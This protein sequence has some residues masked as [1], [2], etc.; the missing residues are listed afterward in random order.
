MCIYEGNIP[1]NHSAQPRTLVGRPRCEQPWLMLQIEIARCVVAAQHAM[2]EVSRR[3][4]HE[5][6]LADFLYL[7]LHVQPVPIVPVNV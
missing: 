5:A 1:L 6:V 4:L 2:P 3:S 7:M